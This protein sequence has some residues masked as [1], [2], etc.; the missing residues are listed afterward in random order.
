MGLVPDRWAE[1]LAITP[2]D[3]SPGRV[4][5]RYLYIDRVARKHPN[6]AAASH[7][8]GRFCQEFKTVVKLHFKCG[9]RKHLHNG[10]THPYVFLSVFC[11]K[12]FDC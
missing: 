5:R 9:I 11:H 6:T 10:A 8:P 2:D 4:V 3:A 12:S 1:R 7:F